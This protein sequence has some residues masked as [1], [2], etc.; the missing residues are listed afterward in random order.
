MDMEKT[1]AIAM[2]GGVDSSVAAALLKEQG[3]EVIGLT[4]CFNL[5]ERNERKPSCCGVIGIEDA[6]RVCHKL[7][8]RHYVINLDRY[9]YREVIQNFYQEY[10][11]G[12]TPNPCIRCNQFIKFDILLKKAVNLGAHFLATGHYAR[13]VN[14]G[15]GILL[16]KALDLRKDQSY[17]LYRLTKWQLKHV[18]FPLGDFTKDKVRQFARRLGL[19]VAEKQDSQEICFLPDGKYRDLIKEKGLSSVKAG[20]LVDKDGNALGRHQ[21]IANYTIGQRQGL[22]IA[23]GYPLYVTE[24][25]PKN[26]QITLGRRQDAYKSE[27]IIKDKHFI[28]RPFKKE[29]EIKIRIRYNHKEMPA[30]VYPFKRKLKAIFKKPQFAITPGQ[31]AVFYDK[32]VVLGGGIIEKVVN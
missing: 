4:M 9:F 32:D 3:Y 13:I 8:I 10:M 14:S 17:F 27:L 21:G 7:G 1:V 15:Q 6:R 20:N 23:K 25:N 26:N 12:R 18:I 19:N 31:S 2:S 11:R 5:A 24:I 22:G 29:I 30:V 28:S 16:K